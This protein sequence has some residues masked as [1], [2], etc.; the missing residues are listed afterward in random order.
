MKFFLENFLKEV[1]KKYENFFLGNFLKEV[2]K[3]YEN[4]FPGKFFL[5]CISNRCR[6]LPPRIG[7]G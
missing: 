1:I 5:Y 4:F 2:I 6:I 7:R 3:K